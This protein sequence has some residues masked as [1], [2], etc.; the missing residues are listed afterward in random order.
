MSRRRL[1]TKTDVVTLPKKKE[2]QSATLGV[3]NDDHGS[4]SRWG[5]AVDVDGM[6]R[7][8]HDSHSVRAHIF[9]ALCGNS[10]MMMYVVPGESYGVRHERRQMQYEYVVVGMRGG[11]SSFQ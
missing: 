11:R 5:R 9:G 1:G 7:K 8:V 4:A 10:W 3:E 2:K 6:N